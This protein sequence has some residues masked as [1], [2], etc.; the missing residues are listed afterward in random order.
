VVP[1]ARVK[2]EGPLK[3]AV[4][5]S[6]APVATKRSPAVAGVASVTVTEPELVRR[7]R[8]CCTSAGVAPLAEM[9]KDHTAIVET[10]HTHAV[11][12]RSFT[13]V[14]RDERRNDRSAG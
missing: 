11:I 6:M 14:L 3:I 12:Q 9:P 2:P 13:S 1:P 10:M 7:P 4:F 5:G 8:L